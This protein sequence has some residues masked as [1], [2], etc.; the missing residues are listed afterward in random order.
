MYDLCSV[1]IKLAWPRQWHASRQ[2][3]TESNY[4]ILS[5]LLIAAISSTGESV[6]LV[7]TRCYGVNQ[8]FSKWAPAPLWIFAIMEG[9]WPKV[10]DCRRCWEEKWDNYK[11]RTTKQFFV[12]FRL[13]KARSRKM[14]TVNLNKLGKRWV[15]DCCCICLISSYWYLEQC[16]LNYLPY[17]V[18]FLCPG[19]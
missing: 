17:M 6:W 3:T 8:W 16:L 4:E 9:R 15:T 11:K 18:G 2:E 7:T 5:I 10:G 12:I 14:T 13:K 19:R 1:A